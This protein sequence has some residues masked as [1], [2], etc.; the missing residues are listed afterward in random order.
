[1]NRRTGSNPDRHIL[2]EG[3]D[4][5]PSAFNGSA[6]EE[7]MVGKEDLIYNKGVN[8]KEE[9]IAPRADLSAWCYSLPPVNTGGLAA[10]GWRS[11]V[12][13]AIVAAAVVIAIIISAA[14]EAAVIFGFFIVFNS[15]F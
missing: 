14:T 9:P 6:F 11:R 5:L 2:R 3:T 10:L 8:T 12:D 1:M 15:I 7:I 13:I 4:A